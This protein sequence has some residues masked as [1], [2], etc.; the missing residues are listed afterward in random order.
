MAP[1]PRRPRAPVPRKRAR[2]ARAQVTVD[3]MVTA[4]ERVLERH[5]PRGLTT[6]R[7][8]EVAGVS[9]GSVYQYFPNKEA[10]VAAVSDR[11]VEQTMRFA[12]VALRAARDVP[13]GRFLE[14]MIQAMV[15]LSRAQLPINRWLV[16]LRTAAA[17][18]ERI[19]REFDVFT[20]ELAAELAARR[21]VA[22]VD[23]H[24]A[25]FVLV[26]L[27]NGVMEALSMR[28]TADVT[29]IV[30]ETRR[31]LAAYAAAFAVPAPASAR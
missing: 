5:G 8:A 11:Y 28:P 13:A 2:D 24:A 14:M 7:V 27:F 26:H 22:F 20:G 31:L 1:A 19:E 17:F 6:N 18:H 12:R 29:A 3:A 30:A 4:A 15:E 9:I 23:P 21:D 25:A 16:E 10:L